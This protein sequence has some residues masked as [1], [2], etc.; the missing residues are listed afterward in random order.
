MSTI[1]RP[2]RPIDDEA[3]SRICLLTGAAGS[4]AEGAH[5][6]PELLGLIFA[7]PYNRLETTFGFVLVDMENLSEYPEGQVV[8]YIVGTSDTK[9]FE[10]VQESTWWPALR[11]KYPKG[12][13]S[14]RTEADSNLINVFIH[15]PYTNPEDI[16][17]H[18]SAH[19][20]IDILSSHQRRGFGRKLMAAAVGYLQEMGRTS[21]FVG[22]DPKNEEAKKFYA[23]LG[24]NRINKEGGEWWALDF[25]DFRA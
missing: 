7:I 6:L 21:L 5:S 15:S 9:K 24:F 25:K 11:E 19:I 13:P 23:N 4:S 2:A 20:H 1:I 17:S 12:N 8:G 14:S 16:T 10:D 18:H 3:L 22:L